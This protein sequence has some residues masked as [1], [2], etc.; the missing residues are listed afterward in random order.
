MIL[1]S[2]R[3]RIYEM[4]PH[5]EKLMTQIMHDDDYNNSYKSQT[6]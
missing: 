4:C 1:K 3:N 5:A 2:I 6:F